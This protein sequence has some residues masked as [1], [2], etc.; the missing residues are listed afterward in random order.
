MIW[1]VQNLVRQNDAHTS[2]RFDVT[3]P[4]Q[5]IPENKLIIC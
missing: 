4:S 5:M 1:I 2:F 3:E